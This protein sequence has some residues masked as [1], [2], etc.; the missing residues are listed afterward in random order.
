MF[1]LLFTLFCLDHLPNPDK[2]FLTLLLHSKVKQKIPRLLSLSLLLD[3]STYLLARIMFFFYL[4]ADF[5]MPLFLSFSVRD[6]K[7]IY[8][9]TTF[10]L[11]QMKH[12]PSRVSLY[13]TSGGS[14]H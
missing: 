10:Y 6:V 8:I 12:I 2:A 4:G 1:F 11:P 14:F 3:P 13:K 7:S 9:D 5:F